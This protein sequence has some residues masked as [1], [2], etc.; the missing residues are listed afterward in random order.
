M[1]YVRIS[2]HKGKPPQYLRALADSIHQAMTECFAVPPADRFQLIHQH[3][4]GEMIFDRDYAGGPRS[5]D[6][7]LVAIQTG[8]PRSAQAKAALYARMAALLA[9]SPGLAPADLMVVISD[10]EMD[11]W[12]FSHGNQASQLPAEAL[13]S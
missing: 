1:P 2:L 7:T 9:A 4:P 3:E 12:S 5:G 6:F 13:K 11:N 10:G 8:R